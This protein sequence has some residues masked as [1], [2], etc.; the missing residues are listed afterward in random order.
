[1]GRK[2][3]EWIYS[4]HSA[5]GELSCFPKKTTTEL[6]I[7]YHMCSEYPESRTWRNDKTHSSWK[8]A[9]WGRSRASKVESDE[10]TVLGWTR[11]SLMTV[12][13]RSRRISS[14]ANNERLSAGK[15]VSHFE[16]DETAHL[17]LG[18]YKS[19]ISSVTPRQVARIRTQMVLNTVGTGSPSNRGLQLTTTQ[20]G[21][22]IV[23][24]C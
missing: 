3:V 7:E 1:M 18:G 20:S 11:S 22:M 16:M 12:T 23:V 17:S 6:A 13:K 5:S 4:K 15:T 8:F 2:A 19:C 14:A 24:W 21:S 9:S 10:L